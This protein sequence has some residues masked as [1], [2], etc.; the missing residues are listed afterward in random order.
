[1]GFF[2]R[3]RPRTFD[4]WFDDATRGLCDFA[5]TWVREEYEDHFAAAYEDLR[6]EGLGEDEAEE[7]A[8][9]TLGNAGHVRRQLRKVYLTRGEGKRL[10]RIL[11]SPLKV[12]YERP[13]SPSRR[14]VRG[15]VLLT[16]LCYFAAMLHL[17][18]GESWGTTGTMVTWGIAFLTVIVP[19]EGF[20]VLTTI[21]FRHAVRARSLADLIVKYAQRNLAVAFWHGWLALF[22]ITGDY[23]SFGQVRAWFFTALFTVLVVTVASAIFEFLLF[24]RIA[25]KMRLYP[26]QNTTQIV[27]E[28]RGLISRAR[29]AQ[30]FD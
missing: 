2:T 21:V 12:D 23:G 5:K 18:I 27:K 20:C 15:F 13:P 3:N 16:W 4:A 10:E 17:R 9:E 29:Q 8:V 11:R 19:R 1:M 25:R 28:L 30:E 6:A 24:Q 14:L 7:A 22:M 26:A